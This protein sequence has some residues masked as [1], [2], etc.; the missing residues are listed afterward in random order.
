MPQIAL[1]R[2]EQDGRFPPLGPQAAVYIYGLMMSGG[3]H[4]RADILLQRYLGH[5]TGEIHDAAAAGLAPDTLVAMTMTTLAEIRAGKP[6]L[7]AGKDV[8]VGKGYSG[9]VAGDLLL[10][11]LRL[12]MHFPAKASL[13]LGTTIL[14]TSYRGTNFPTSRSEI[15]E[16]FRIHRSV[17]HL[18]AAF[19]NWPPDAISW[20][21]PAGLPLFLAAAEALRR[22][23]ERHILPAGKPSR[24]RLLTPGE[25]WSLPDTVALPDNRLVYPPLSEAEL[26]LIAGT[27]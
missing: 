16:A 3:D 5:A 2:L 21:A 7:E 14:G 1:A 13:N 18:W 8:W 15:L 22:D 12:A 20:H 4:A 25:T 10:T 23:G 27:D 24:P 19:N 26:R 11:V 17:A 6:P 9:P